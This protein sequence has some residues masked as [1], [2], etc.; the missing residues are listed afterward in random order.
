M[1]YSGLLF[2]SVCSLTLTCS[3]MLE[4]HLSCAYASPL[5]QGNSM[6]LAELPAGASYCQVLTC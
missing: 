6:V 2:L 1:A 5:V 3:Y 4:Q